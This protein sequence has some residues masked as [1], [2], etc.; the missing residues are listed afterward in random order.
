[1]GDKVMAN[2]CW[3]QVKAKGKKKNLLFLYHSMPSN[4]DTKLILEKDNEIIFRGSCKWS[5]DAYCENTTSNIKINVDDY[6]DD[7]YLLAREI[8]KYIYY[9]LK[10]KSKIL[11]LEI[12]VFSEYEDYDYKNDIGDKPLFEHYLKGKLVEQKELSFDEAKKLA[13][14]LFQI[15]NVI[16]NYYDNYSD[17]DDYDDFGEEYDENG[18]SI[19][20]NILYDYNN[21]L[22]EEIIIPDKVN[23]INEGFGYGYNKLKKV[24][25]P[26]SVNEIDFDCFTDLLNL[27]EVIFLGNTQIFEGCFNNCPKLVIKCLSSSKEVIDYANKNNIK[28][29]LTN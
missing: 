9:T 17:N 29:E 18:F 10:D 5:L 20:D 12:E 11:D 22:A 25:I 23:F 13:K 27:E 28:I 2:F 15:D 8:D 7:D 3:Y 24:V 14:E 4:D 19:F 21:N 6:I 16:P 26:A 1:M